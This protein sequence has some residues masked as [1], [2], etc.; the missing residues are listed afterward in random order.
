MLDVGVTLTLF[1]LGDS[2][3]DQIQIYGD[4]DFRT[5]TTSSSA[6]TG[7]R[8]GYINIKIGGTTKKLYY[9]S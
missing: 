9:Y 3:S 1:L 6:A 5:N 8:E 4:V 2:S 7:N